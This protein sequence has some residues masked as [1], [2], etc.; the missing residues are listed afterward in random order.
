MAVAAGTATAVPLTA[1]MPSVA[2]PKQTPEQ[3]L[4]AA[5]GLKHSADRMSKDD[6]SSFLVYARAG[7]AFIRAAIAQEAANAKP[8]F[9]TTAK[10]LQFAQVGLARTGQTALAGVCQA[11]AAS[12]LWRHYQRTRSGAADSYKR[13]EAQLEEAARNARPLPAHEVAAAL[14]YV[15]ESRVLPNSLDGWQ[16][17]RAL[18]ASDGASLPA[19]DVREVPLADVLRFASARLDAA[20]A[21][22]V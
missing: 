4:A 5:T 15:R 6:P 10:L 21:A 16:K 18:L 11:C 14:Q 3:L 13:V 22:A 2:L 12:A 20:S 1:P 17:A 19:A 9:L 8:D 7:V